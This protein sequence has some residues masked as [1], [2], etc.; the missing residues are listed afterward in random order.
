MY[1]EYSKNPEI[2]K[3]RMYYEMIEQALPGV[4]LYIDTSDGATQKLLP[5]ENFVSGSA[6]S[7]CRADRPKQKL[8]YWSR[9]YNH[10][11]RGCDIAMHR[12]A[13]FFADT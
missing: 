10:R 3:I 6:R 1:D 12:Q 9:S 8:C 5:L 4:K 11:S 13:V 2:T 7:V